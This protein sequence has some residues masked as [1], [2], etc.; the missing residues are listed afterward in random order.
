MKKLIL[1]TTIFLLSVC[2]FSP[3]TLAETLYE[4]QF[5]I[6]ESLQVPGQDVSYFDEDQPT[7]SPIANF[8]LRIINFITTVIGSVAIILFIIAGFKFMTAQGNEQTLTEGKDIARY[9]AVGLV[10]VFLSY[11]IVIFIQNLFNIEL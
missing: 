6:G 2:A 9:A 3:L 11:M 10:I 5:D 4:T 1:I 7:S 8:V